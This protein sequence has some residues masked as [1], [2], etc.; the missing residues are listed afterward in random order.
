MISVRTKSPGW[1]GFFIGMFSFS[2][3]ALVIVFQIYVAN[4]IFN[5]INPEGKSPIACHAETPGSL[6]P[7]AERMD[8]P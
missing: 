7:A 8:L 5:G 4:L 2:L 1:G 6:S 3:F